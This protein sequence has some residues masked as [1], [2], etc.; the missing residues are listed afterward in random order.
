MTHIANQ[1]NMYTDAFGR[2][3]D[4]DMTVW[5]D[6]SPAMH[7]TQGRGI[8]PMLVV[9][10]NHD[11]SRAEQAESMAGLLRKAGIRADMLDIP[12]EDHV[13]LTDHLG[14]PG[15]L[16]TRVILDFFRSLRR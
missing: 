6:A 15:D 1:S 16:C 8:A 7:V 10:A 4:R 12:D 9:H 3:P 13:M 2:D 5:L 11:A 14:M